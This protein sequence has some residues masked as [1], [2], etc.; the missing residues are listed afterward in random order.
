M[1]V[2]YSIRRLPRAAMPSH[3]E[4][5]AFAEKLAEETS[6]ELLMHVPDSRVALLSKLSKPIRLGRGC[7]SLHPTL[8]RESSGPEC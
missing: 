1:H 2:G 7:R 8:G 3:E 6:Y 5:L 4:V